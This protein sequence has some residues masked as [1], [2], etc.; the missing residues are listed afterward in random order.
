MLCAIHALF[1]LGAIFLLDDLRES[2]VGKGGFSSV[3]TVLIGT[4][5]VLLPV[6][7]IGM[8]LRWRLGWIA[9]LAIHIGI[10]SWGLTATA[11]SYFAPETLAEIATPQQHSALRLVWMVFV[12]VGMIFYLL[13]E[14]TQTYFA[15][16]NS[17]NLSP[18]RCFAWAAALCAAVAAI[19]IAVA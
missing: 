7:A 13:S 17:C 2:L 12:H 14:S 18:G 1:F 4:L 6:S 9:A 16:G 5:S 3:R 15:F 10:L 11:L 19:C 8:W